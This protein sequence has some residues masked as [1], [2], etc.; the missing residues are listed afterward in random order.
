MVK[1]NKVSPRMDTIVVTMG[2][3]KIGILSTIKT[4]HVYREDKI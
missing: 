1:C 3:I 2:G 4:Q